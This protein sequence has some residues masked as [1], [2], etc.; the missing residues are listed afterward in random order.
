MP[1]TQ[2]TEFFLSKN[3][4]KLRSLTGHYSS[5]KSSNPPIKH[6]IPSDSIDFKFNNSQKP[7]I[8]L[9]SNLSFEGFSMRAF[10]NLFKETHVPLGKLNDAIENYGKTFGESSQKLFIK[11]IESLKDPNIK[12]VK[13]ETD[14]IVFV[15]SPLYKDIIKS[16]SAPFTELPLDMANGTISLLRKIPAL[17]NNETLI[18][19]QNADLLKKR[20]AKI[21]KDLNISSVRGYLENFNSSNPKKRDSILKNG[22]SYLDNNKSTFNAIHERCGTRLTTGI[23]GSIFVANDAYNLSRVVNDKEKEASFEKEKRFKQELNRIG[24]NIL[25]QFITI[26]ALS[27]YFNKSLKTAV[28]ITAGTALA[29]EAFGRILSGTPIIPLT[30][31]MAQK[32]KEKDDKKINSKTPVNFQSRNKSEQNKKDSKINFNNAIKVAAIGIGLIGTGFGLIKLRNTKPYESI[33]NVLFDNK[34]V[35]KDVKFET[36]DYNKIITKL[37][38]NGFNELVDKYKNVFSDVK[39]DK[40]LMDLGKEERIWGKSLVDNVFL[41]PAKLISGVVSLP[42]KVLSKVVKKLPTDVYKFDDNL[43]D[44]FKSAR[45]SLSYLKKYMDESD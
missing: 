35:R 42:Y 34:L 22:L 30:R 26:G 27:K 19:W 1:G 9:N 18:K 13:V 23:A 15:D 12:N 5:F 16:T 11:T 14:K 33:V 45:T 25:F 8:P 32:S 2:K 28:G 20:I 41:M 38:K 37:E 21:E 39:L 44:E 36:S 10:K 6:S 40:P 3:K 17:K 4:S 31:S 24:L 7:S 43:S 29:S